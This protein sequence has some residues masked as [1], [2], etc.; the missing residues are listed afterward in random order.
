MYLNKKVVGR[1]TTRT[2]WEKAILRST[3]SS[4]AR[5][6]KI[7]NDSYP[8]EKLEWEKKLEILIETFPVVGLLPFIFPQRN[9]SLIKYRV[10]LTY[11]RSVEYRVNNEKWESHYN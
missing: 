1:R 3:A 6:E 2:R 11:Q 7:L 10:C 5:N 9:R 4:N 8:E